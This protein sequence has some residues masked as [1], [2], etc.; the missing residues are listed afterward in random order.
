MP[1]LRLMKKQLWVRLTEEVLRSTAPSLTTAQSVWSSAPTCRKSAHDGRATVSRLLAELGRHLLRCGELE[2]HA[3]LC[4]VIFCRATWAH[5]SLF[6]WRPNFWYFSNTRGP[7]RL[8]CLTLLDVYLLQ[9]IMN[10]PPS[11]SGD[12]SGLSLRWA[13][14]STLLR[15][16]SHV[17]V[18]SS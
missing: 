4:Q 1:Y 17:I 9:S 15:N 2:R 14:Y 3:T 12:F 18:V 13:V 16:L 11:A 8:T 10:L 7:S 5:H 6:V